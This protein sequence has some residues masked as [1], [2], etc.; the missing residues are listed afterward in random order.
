MA[1][2]LT[3]ACWY[4][5]VYG[6][7]VMGGSMSMPG[8]WAMSMAWMPMPGQSAVE[9]G[10][11]FL[12]MWEIMM[13]A[14]M[15]PSALPLLLLHRHLRAGRGGALAPDAVLLAGYFAVWLAFGVIAY[16][17]GRAVTAAVM[18]STALS[19]SI[20][21]A[22]GIVLLASG[23]YQCTPW[24]Q[25]CLAHCRS[26]RSFLFQGWSP[27]W[28]GTF[29]LGL[30]HGAY[31]AGCCWALMAMQCAIGLMNLPMMVAVAGVILV[32]KVWR[33]G[34]RLATA[35]GV[36]AV[37]WGLVVLGRALGAL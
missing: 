20:P 10:L 29:H 30:R 25:R 15:L 16:A 4:A 13:V 28:H 23:I 19:R 27:T 24:K 9:A 12:V 31:C 17:L 34:D 6:G 33:A 8:G 26:P 11:M 14:M 7:R 1:L 5:T 2:L 22:T 37:G 36:A 35:V 3:A 18:E 32:E 21:A